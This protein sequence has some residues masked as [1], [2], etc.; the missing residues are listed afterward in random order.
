MASEALSRLVHGVGR[1]ESGLKTT[2]CKT[3]KSGLS[4][5]R[6]T[7]L[8]VEPNRSRKSI[9]RSIEIYIQPLESSESGG[10]N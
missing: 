2:E 9:A 8:V 10:R 1:A 7:S 6:G 5:A 4:F 3:S